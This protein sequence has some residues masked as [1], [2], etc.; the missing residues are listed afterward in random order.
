MGDKPIEEIARLADEQ[1]QKGF[2]IWQKWT[3]PNCGS[4]QTMSEPN[5]L[6]RSGRCHECEQINIITECGF[7]LANASGAEIV[8]ASLEQA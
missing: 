5:L 2:T 1:I 3:C 7:M 6:Y 8:Q 4:R